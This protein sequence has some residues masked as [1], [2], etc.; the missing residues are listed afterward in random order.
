MV[1]FVLLY[2]GGGMPETEEEQATIMKAW[3]SWYGEL[4]EAVVDG[5]NPFTP[6]AKSIASDLTVTDGPVGTMASGYTIIKA[7]S[8]DEAV[9]LAKGC[10]IIPGGGSVTVYET[11][12]AM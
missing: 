12:A 2:S 1:N 8:L 4:G 9:Q 6:V 7:N 5:G 3:E 10:P 11:F